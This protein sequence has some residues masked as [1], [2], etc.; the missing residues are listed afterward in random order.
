MPHLL[1][2]IDLLSGLPPET[3]LVKRIVIKPP[4]F[5]FSLIIIFFDILLN[6]VDLFSGEAINDLL[7]KVLALLLEP[8]I[9]LDFIFRAAIMCL[10]DVLVNDLL[11]LGV[12]VRQLLD[13]HERA[14]HVRVH[15]FARH[16]LKALV[17]PLV[18]VMELAEKVVCLAQIFNS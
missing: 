9:G 12:Q 18:Y 4:Q 13:R 16:L 14:A 2:L 11:G 3:D 7:G 15:F 8:L 17:D 10:V 1:K 6:E 5:F